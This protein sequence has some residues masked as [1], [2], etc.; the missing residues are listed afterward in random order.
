MYPDDDNSELQTTNSTGGFFEGLAGLGTAA[1]QWYQ[2]LNPRTVAPIPA[3]PA[4]R[5]APSAP[6]G[7]PMLGWIIGGV[8]LVIGLVLALRK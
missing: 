6:L 5:P 7:I 3:A 2:A 4:A 8:V 1:A